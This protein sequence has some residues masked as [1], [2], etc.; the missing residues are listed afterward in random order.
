DWS[1]DVCSSDLLPRIDRCEK[2]ETLRVTL[3]DAGNEVVGH[4]WAVGRRLGI[5]GK[6]DAEDLFLG[7]LDSELVDCALVHVT[8]EIAGG[9]VAVRA[10]APIQPLLERQMNM[11]VDRAD[12]AYEA[13]GSASSRVMRS[14]TAIDPPCTTRATMPRR[15]TSSSFSPIRISS[16]RKHGSQTFVISSTALS[17]NLTR[18]PTGRPITCRPSTVRFSLI[19]PASTRTSSS[20]TPWARLRFPQARI[21]APAP[22]VPGRTS[23]SAIC[24]CL[25]AL[26][27]PWPR[28]KAPLRWSMRSWD[29][30]RHAWPTR[31]SRPPRKSRKANLT[32]I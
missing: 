9:P 20:A 2:R 11:Q 19:A 24:G 10:H 3:D 30:W 27:A 23:R 12:Q 26:S 29:C 31:S 8:P 15:P 17:P 6:Q 21:T 28:S 5:P 4:R 25:A 1:S 7:E 18:V 32:G 13:S 16:M 22:S 14:P